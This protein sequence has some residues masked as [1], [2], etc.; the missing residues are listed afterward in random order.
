M[1]RFF[2]ERYRDLAPYVP[3]EQPR[4]R[5]YIKLNT[6]ESPYPPAPSVAQAVK[7]AAESLNLY[8]DPTCTALRQALGELLGLE[9]ENLIMTNGSD[10]VLAYIF[11]A[12][13]QRPFLFPEHTYGFYRVFCDLYGVEYSRVPLRE[14]FSIDVEPY[15]DSRYNV[16]F[17]NPNAPTGRDL[18]LS[19]IE[20]LLNASPDRLVIVDEAYVDFG[21]SSALGLMGKYPNLIVV[22]TFSK[23][24]SLAGGRLGFACAQ[25][26]LIADLE[27]IRYSQNPYNV[28]ALTQSAG[29]ATLREEVYYRACAEKIKH[30]RSV[31]TSGLEALG[32]TVVPSKANFVFARAPGLSG[33]A[34]Y[35][36][37]RARGVLVRHFEKAGIEDYVR[38]TVGTPEETLALLAE[39]GKVLEE[40]K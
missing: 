39:C 31:M 21:G 33:R 19:D 13:G 20:R 37:L 18:P 1:S 30:S 22:R 6:N 17:A 29:L 27:A 15:M 16:I 38:I 40:G 24:R 10:E 34:L 23:S 35:E 36:G 26:E 32:F 28:S 9:P 12:Y 11:L 8:C 5:R 7:K 4:D 2:A 14:D 25:K 3:G